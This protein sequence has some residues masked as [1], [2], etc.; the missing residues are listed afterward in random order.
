MTDH[1]QWFTKEHIVCENTVHFDRGR[2]D[3]RHQL[4]ELP[5][6]ELVRLAAYLTGVL[7]DRFRQYPDGQP[8][9]GRRYPFYPTPASVATSLRQDAR[10][11][12]AGHA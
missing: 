7:I 2:D 4:H 12:E 1:T 3:I 8:S 10:A 5:A 11:I 6:D 9:D